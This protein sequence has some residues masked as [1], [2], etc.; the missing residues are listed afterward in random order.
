MLGAVFALL[1]AAAAGPDMNAPR[2]ADLVDPTI[3]SGVGSCMPGPCLPH[4]SIYPSPDTTLP[5]PSG[6][7]PGQPVVGFSQLHTQGTGGLPSYGNFLVSPQTGGVEIDEAR[8]A[9]PAEDEHA[10]ATR[11]DVRLARYGVDCS[12]VPAKHA[13]LYTFRF[14]PAAADAAVVVDVGRKI[15]EFA[16]DVRPD[17][18]SHAALAVVDGAVSVDPKSATM[19]G[20]GTFDG[21]WAPGVYHLFFAAEFDRPPT[22][23]GT[24]TGTARHDGGTAATAH[25][26]PLGGYVRLAGGTVR[27]R[28]AV[29]FKSVEQARTW[30]AAEVPDWDADALQARAKAAWDE[31]LRRVTFGPTPAEQQRALYTALWHAQVQPRDRTGDNWTSDEPFWDD[32]YTLW[33]SWK[34]LFPLVDLID[35]QT[36]AAVVNSFVARHR[37]NSDGYVATAFVAGLEYRT[38]QGGDEADNV[39]ADAYAKGV[40]GVDWAGA[41]DVLKAHA[42]GV[43]RTADYR[44]MGY[45]P[46]GER[47]TFG[48]RFHSGSG[49]L[50]FAQNDFSAALVADG[51][52]HADDA[53][54]W[55]ARSQNWRNVWDAAAADA[56]FAGFPRS[57]RADGTFTADGLRKNYNVDFY[58]ATSWEACFMPVYDRDEL[59]A[60]TGGRQRFV[61]RLT[62]AL[63]HGLIDFGNEPSFMTIWLFAAEDRPD[64]TSVRAAKYRDLYHG[65]HLPGDD[66]QGA[67][68]SMYVFLCAGLYPIAGQDLYYLHG[69]SVPEVSFHLENGRTFTITAAAAGPTNLYIQGVTLNGVPL[70]HP[71]IRH[72][73]LERGGTLAF[74]MGATPP[75]GWPSP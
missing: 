22:A 40:T 47:T 61:D 57:R 33:D 3:G 39:I 63:D 13:A 10:A 50:A 53:K 71:V 36:S 31:K 18:P 21:N 54:R 5:Q 75:P 35:R 6:Y 73:D 38:G 9:S 42:D 60:R 11:Y 30:L 55:R 69:P 49:T 59:V 65:A 66:D 48:R 62:Y 2:P 64:L 45:S 52:G 28:I 41:Y 14:D 12:V 25:R 51:L 46:V 16:R 17:H 37:H 29:S 32:H 27:M 15:G 43:G 20:G 67:M 4:A 1:A 7:R 58:E 56:G 23:V 24:W 44:S 70:P 34:T 8:H 19:T 26:Q 74:T 68:S 72:A